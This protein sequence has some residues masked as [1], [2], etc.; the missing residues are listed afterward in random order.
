MLWV[1]A[2]E[3]YVYTLECWGKAGEVE[4]MQPELDKVAQSMR[5]K[6]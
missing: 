5:I 1:V 3:K 6:P 4:K 2:T